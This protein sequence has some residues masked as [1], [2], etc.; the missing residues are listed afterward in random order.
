MSKDERKCWNRSNAEDEGCEPK[1]KKTGNGYEWD[2]FQT[3]QDSNDAAAADDKRKLPWLT[4]SGLI[5]RYLSPHTPTTM[6]FALLLEG[7]GLDDLANGKQS[8]FR[9]LNQELPCSRK[10]DAE[11]SRAMLL[12]RLLLLLLRLL[13]TPWNCFRRASPPRGPLVVQG[14]G[15]SQS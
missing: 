1:M 12:L 11:A 2:I 13:R 10:G 4:S 8:L 7:A 3:G 5:Q 15:T 6:L 14:L 9:Q